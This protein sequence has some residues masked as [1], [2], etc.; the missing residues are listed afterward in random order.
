M[1]SK[2]LFSIFSLLIIACGLFVCTIRDDAGNPVT[3]NEQVQEEIP[4]LTILPYT[5]IAS[6]DTLALGIFLW[7]D[8]VDT[9]PIANEKVSVSAS[10]GWLS[11]STIT[12]D[13]N[14]YATVYFSDTLVVLEEETRQI[15]FTYLTASE[16][17]TII[18]SNETTI[19][20]THY[21]A[22]SATP[23]IIEAD[24][25]SQSLV[26]VKIKNEKFN[27]ISGKSISF[28]T[29]AGD[30]TAGSTTDDA[31]KATALLT[32]ER[33][34][35]TARIIATLDEDST[36]YAFIEVDFAGVTITSSA[37]PQS[38]IPNGVDF[39]TITMTL[40]DAAGNTIYG[41]KVRFTNS[42]GSNTTITVL[43]SV[44]DTRGQAQCI[45]TGT[46][47]G[48]DTIIIKA[49]GDSA[50][51]VI[52]Y[53]SSQITFD[54]TPAAGT[55]HSYCANGIDSTRITV[56]FLAGNGS[57]ISG[58]AVNISATSGAID[59]LFTKIGTTNT[60][61][62]IYFYLKNPDFATTATISAVANYS[63]EITSSSFDLY[64]KADQIALIELGGSPEVISIGGDIS[65]ITALVKDANGNLV[66]DEIISFKLASGPGA[67]EYLNPPT[68][69]TDASG[70]AITTLVSGKSPSKQQDVWVIASSFSGIKSNTIKFTIAGPPSHVTFGKD[71]GDIVEYP[72]GTYGLKCA[73]LVT[74]INHNPVKNGTNATFSLQVTG[75]YIYK[76]RSDFMCDSM[77]FGPTYYPESLLVFED[78]NDN[79]VNDPDETDHE[80]YPMYR[81][82]DIVWFEGDRNY[83]PGPAFYDYNCNGRRDYNPNHYN[84]EPPEPYRE[85]LISDTLFTVYKDFN[86]NFALDTAEPLVD[87]TIDDATYEA[88]TDFIS[89]ISAYLPGKPAVPYGYPDMDWNNSLT[90]DPVKTSTV[91][92][93]RNVVTE[94]GKAPNEIIYLQ[95]DALRLRARVWVESNGISSLNKE[96][97]MLPIEIGDANYFEPLDGKKYH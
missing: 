70:I 46:G 77:S 42:S 44:T 10:S 31:G 91:K 82:E 86:G 49:A 6:G 92:I 87:E 5:P 63:N 26:T 34:N 27:P 21:M 52:S 30:I 24:G 45:V 9:T 12:T 57:P 76:R 25:V 58:A 36:K 55:V 4:H 84:Y 69:I 53:S 33:R 54:T 75:F 65:N 97:F 17:I 88:H 43:D 14:G 51:S 61:G 66:K 1:K 48:Q 23:Y 95:S 11:A 90:A 74:D 38:I 47:T 78:I 62:K 50:R 8:T 39:S 41:E 67:G 16:A 96:E 20:Q 79:Y 64:F 3:V 35:K 83:N 89:D 56:T 28:T 59:T 29:N 13:D 40:K 80:G 60:S 2:K 94:D 71:V 85:V 18:I 7:K 68:A 81:G 19:L 32:S 37:K 93:V 22:I 73:A 15:T 72:D